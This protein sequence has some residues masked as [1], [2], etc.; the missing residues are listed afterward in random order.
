MTENYLFVYGT[1]RKDTTRH[2][3]LQRFCEFIDIGTLQGQL[4]LVDYY[5]GVI[6]SD[7]SRQLVFGEVYRIYNYQLLFAALDDYEECSS[8]FSQPHEYVRQQLMVSLSDGHKLK[9][10]VY[11]YNRPVSGLKLIASGDFL[12]P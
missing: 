5:P 1:L 8:S 2:D 12:N 10:W 11:L 3:L 6:T 9:A 4:Y 7:D